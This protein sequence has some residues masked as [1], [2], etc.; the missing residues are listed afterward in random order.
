MPVR[1]L[2]YDDD[3]DDDDGGDDAATD[4]FVPEPLNPKEK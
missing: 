2:T 1:H 4:S 3:N